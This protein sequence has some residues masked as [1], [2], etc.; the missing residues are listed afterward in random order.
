MARAQ[1][2]SLNEVQAHSALGLW[3]LRVLFRLSVL[4]SA[5]VHVSRDKIGMSSAHGI[6]DV[7]EDLRSASVKNAQPRIGC[8]MYQREH[9]SWSLCKTL[10]PP[11]LPTGPQP[12]AHPDRLQ[13]P[14]AQG[15]EGHHHRQ[16]VGVL[17]LFASFC[18]LLHTQTGTDRKHRARIGLKRT[19]ACTR[20]I[21]NHLAQKS[22]PKSAR[23]MQKT[24]DLFW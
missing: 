2:A 1:G 9:H 16:K 4:A 10:E 15:V 21:M 17:G 14:S 7:T 18:Q 3:P 6:A 23:R 22:S 8:V 24:R 12:S 13:V 5:A 11:H 19:R 20:L